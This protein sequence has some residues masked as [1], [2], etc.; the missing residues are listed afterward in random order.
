MPELNLSAPPVDLV[1][2][3][4][5]RDYVMLESCTSSVLKMGMIILLCVTEVLEIY[6]CLRHTA[7][8][9]IGAILAP[10]ETLQW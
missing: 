5:E 2:I 7:A 3:L 1:L 6:A 4:T 8:K 10:A 9:K